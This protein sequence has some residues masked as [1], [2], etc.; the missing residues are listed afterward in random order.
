MKHNLILASSSPRRRELLE[1]TGIKFTVIEPGNENTYNG[2]EE[3]G[4]FVKGNAR[5]KSL[6][7]INKAGENDYILS[8]D[9]VVVVDNIVLGK[10]ADKQDAESMLGLLSGRTHYVLTGY[11]IISWDGTV[12]FEEAVTTEVKFKELTPSEIEGYIKTGE[13]FDKAGSYG[14]QG[15]GSFMVLG[16][17]GSYTNVVGLPVARVISKLQD[18]N[19]INIFD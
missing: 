6:S 10:P 5:I 14:I 4:L 2:S 16:L 11:S 1:K 12:Y 8:A 17:N 7:V 18:L 19:I 15:I 3:P 13:P 9:T